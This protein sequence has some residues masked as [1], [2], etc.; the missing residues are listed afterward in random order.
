MK[1]DAPPILVK[2]CKEDGYVLFPNEYKNGSFISIEDR[3][4]LHEIYIDI[5]RKL[6]YSITNR[7]KNKKKY[8]KDVV[9]EIVSHTLPGMLQVFLNLSVRVKKAIDDK[10]GNLS[11]VKMSNIFIPDTIEEFVG[12]A[13]ADYNFNADLV[14]IIGQVFGLSDSEANIDYIKNSNLQ[15]TF[16]NNNSRLY[17]RNVLNGIVRRLQ[18]VYYLL[19]NVF[20]TPEFCVLN[21][22]IL[23]SPFT[24]KGLYGKFF[25]KIS[26]D[27]DVTINEYDGVLRDDIFKIE[28]FDIDEIDVFLDKINANHKQRILYKE[29]LVSFFCTYYPKH[30]LEMFQDYINLM[31]KQIHRNRTKAIIIGSTCTQSLYFLSLAKKNG[32]KVFSLQHGGYFGYLKLGFYNHDSWLVEYQSC[33]H[34]LTW[35]WK[36]NDRIYS[37]EY[38]FIPFVSP[39]LSE[40]KQFWKRNKIYLFDKH[41]YDVLIA[42]TRLTELS[43]EVDFN[44]IDDILFRPY[45]LI[46]IVQELSTENINMLYK[47]PSLA[48]SRS[49]YNA[50]SK[51]KEIGGN[52]FSIINNIDKGLSLEL[53]EQSSIILWDVVGTGFLECMAS[54]IP[55]MVYISTYLLFTRDMVSVLQKLEKVGIVHTNEKTLLRAVKLY[56]NNKN[57]WFFDVERKKYIRQFTNLFCNT[58]KN[59]DKEL[60]NEIQ[61]KIK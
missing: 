11:V 28:D 34:Y 7:L 57:D 2:K 25:K 51:M 3:L 16:V 37:D 33:S 32:I 48:S 60:I 39:W 4:K 35:G 9:E 52:N 30:S 1:K 36:G 44:T 10:N 61:S 24:I 41:T 49:Y 47:S 31:S 45:D 14:Y 6:I 18:Q 26:L 27:T 40:R 59:W 43:T 58:S 22:S 56:K 29:A 53:L 5:Y 20:Y 50:L 55:T 23:D 54:D 42:P 13:K 19:R 46:R 17:K 21:A 15:K 8:D 12:K 38:K